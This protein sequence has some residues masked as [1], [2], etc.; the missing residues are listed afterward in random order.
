[1]SEVI[2]YNIVLHNKL[3]FNECLKSEF[4]NI[5]YKEVDISKITGITEGRIYVNETVDSQVEW[6]DELNMYTQDQF[7]KNDY[8]N[9][10]N[11]AIMMLRYNEKIFS[12]VYGYGRT[13][14][15]NAAIEKN[16]GL[17]TAINLISDE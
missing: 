17:R 7:D 12:I 10:S 8:N 4:T 13:M 3:E 1:M 15:N 11:K 2:K 16:F 5:E 6:I 9:R 14:L